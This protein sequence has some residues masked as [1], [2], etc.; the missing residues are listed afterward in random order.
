MEY[1]AR[2]NNKK[3]HVKNIRMSKNNK[4]KTQRLQIMT[5]GS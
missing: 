2:N 3:K 1:E 4:L 5:G